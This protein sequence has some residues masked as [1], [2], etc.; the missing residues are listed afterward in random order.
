MSK[1]IK[2]IV[3]KGSKKELWNNSKKEK[4]YISKADPC[5]KNNYA[6]I[7]SQL[8]ELFKQTDDLH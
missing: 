3:D 4:T 8:V 6:H 1:D 7:H 2:R 5:D